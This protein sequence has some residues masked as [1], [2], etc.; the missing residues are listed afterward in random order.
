MAHKGPA[1]SD[2]SFNPDDSPEA[3]NNLSVHTC[4]SDCMLAARSM[5]GPDESPM[6]G[7]GN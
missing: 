1:M 3:Y 6:F 2:V 5:Y 7:V 4:I